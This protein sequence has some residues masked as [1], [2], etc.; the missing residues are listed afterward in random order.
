MEGGVSS[1]LQ[2]AIIVALFVVLE[3]ASGIV[4]FVYRNEV[5]S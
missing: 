2:Y 3:L 1:P 5:V 4:G